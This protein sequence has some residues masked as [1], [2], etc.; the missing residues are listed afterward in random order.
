MTDEK[1]RKFELLLSNFQSTGKSQSFL[2]NSLVGFFLLVW[3]LELWQHSAGGINIQFL[4]A[5]ITVKGLW[6]IVPLVNCLLVLQIVGSINLITHAWRR[7]DLYIPEVFLNQH[8]F[9][10]AEFDP[11]KNVLDHLAALKLSLDKPILPDSAESP[12]ANDQK[13][14]F[15]AFI[16]P[17]LVLFATFTTSFA[18]RRISITYTSAI[19]V[20]C[21]TIL[22]AAFAIP[23]IWRKT[24]LFFGV[25]KNGYDG[26]I[27]GSDAYYRM[28][29]T[30]R[31]V[32]H[33]PDTP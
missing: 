29:M 4:G 30:A 9:F 31:L 15:R 25:H 7:L 3:S 10:F 26:I 12:T 14:D 20:I 2:V 19:Y 13:H 28:S 1:W 18:M 6:P 32:K 33:A 17:A 21:M 27:W 5:S 8:D 11:H 22:P 23:F 24:C 16:Y